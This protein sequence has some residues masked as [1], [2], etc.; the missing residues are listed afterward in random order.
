MSYR[1]RN[2]PTSS[3]RN[4]FH[5]GLF[6]ILITEELGKLESSWSHFLF[7]GGFEVNLKPTKKRK[8]KKVLKTS[9]STESKP[10][11]DNKFGDCDKQIETEEVTSA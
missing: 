9:D 1:V 2:H 6:K 7:W 8:R 3:G 4:M 11:S 5:H 10:L